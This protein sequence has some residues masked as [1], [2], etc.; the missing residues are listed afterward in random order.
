MFEKMMSV[1][2]ALE[3]F[4]FLVCAGAA[5]SDPAGDVRGWRRDASGIFPASTPATTWS[6]ESNVIWK[7]RTKTWSNASPILLGDRVFICE[8]PET[9]LCFSLA[10]GALL[11]SAT[12]G[13]VDAQEPSRLESWRKE[14]ERAEALSVRLG[15]AEKNAGNIGSTLKKDPASALLSNEL[16][17]ARA[18]VETLQNEFGPCKKYLRP[19][20]HDANGYSSPT[21]ATDGMAVYVLFGSGTVAAYTPEGRRLWLRDTE[22]RPHHYWGHS[23][24]PVLVNT[25]VIVC[26]SNRVVALDKATGKTTWDVPALSGFGTPALASVEGQT[27]IVTPGGDLVSAEGKPLAKSVLKLPWTSP[28]AVGDVVYGL[29]AD[30]AAAIRLTPAVLE[31]AAPE[32]LWQQPIKKQRYYCSAL[33][34]DGLLYTIGAQGHLSVLD[35]ATGDLVWEKAI[36]ADGTAY[37]SICAAGGLLFAGFESGMTVVFKPGREYTEVASNQLPGFRSTPVFSGARMLVRTKD[38]LYC[39]GQDRKDVP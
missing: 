14:A 31:G 33:L 26:M 10:D 4:M 6:A 37:S 7:S 22:L 12:N 29:D 38:G 5:Q 39:I 32:K 9:L 25:N 16:A 18:T 28:I 17:E 3:V 21:P 30:G 23:S 2:A 15:E 19:E 20:T 24:S 36:K 27:V 1:V 8:E 11:W 34:L 35:A 13:Y